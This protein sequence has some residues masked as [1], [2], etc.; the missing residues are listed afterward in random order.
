MNEVKNLIFK[1]CDLK[2]I[3]DGKVFML[4]GHYFLLEAM[5]GVVLETEHRYD[6]MCPKVNGLDEDLFY[7]NYVIISTEA[8]HSEF[9]LIEQ[10]RPD[11]FKS[12]TKA[13]E[14]NSFDAMIALF[15]KIYYDKLNSPKM[16][17]FNTG[18]G[19]TFNA[20]S[21]DLSSLTPHSI[22]TENTVSI[23]K[24]V[25]FSN[26][27][28]RKLI[29]NEYYVDQIF[30]Q[31]KEEMEELGCTHYTFIRHDGSILRRLQLTKDVELRAVGLKK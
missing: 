30:A 20:D 17:R 25:A 26:T 4:T 1:K 24:R 12:S 10:E 14:I 18:G 13:S 29:L 19:V 8:I 23:V 5:H 7:D 3:S 31:I 15:E 27:L 6:D 2:R 9:D 11:G 16:R 22:I 28:L 21:G